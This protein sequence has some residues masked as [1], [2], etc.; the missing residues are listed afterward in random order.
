MSSWPAPS[1]QDNSGV[2]AYIFFSGVETPEGSPDLQALIESG[3]IRGAVFLR[4]GELIIALEVSDEDQARAIERILA[5]II[6][7]TREF[8][9]T[10]ETGNQAIIQ[11]WSIP[12]LM[13]CVS[14]FASDDLDGAE[15][16]GRIVADNR[17]AAVD[18]VRRVG[19]DQA[20]TAVLVQVTGRSRSEIMLQFAKAISAAKI[21]PALFY[22]SPTPEERDRRSAFRAPRAGNQEDTPSSPVASPSIHRVAER[23]GVSDEEALRAAGQTLDWI[24]SQIADGGRFVLIKGRK[25]YRVRFPR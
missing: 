6:H 11:A 3:L 10:S 18:I 25:R 2:F 4:R 9:L 22:F 13:I 17:E 19:D 8:I 24:D 14:L 16:A 1:E 5:E 20:R 23:R 12:D 21:N 7:R 15:I